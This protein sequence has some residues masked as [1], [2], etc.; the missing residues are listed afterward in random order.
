MKR[1]LLCTLLMTSLAHASDEDPECRGRC[2]ASY[3]T[4]TQSCKSPPGEPF[5][6]RKVTACSNRCLKEAGRCNRVCGSK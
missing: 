6:S 2:S 3:Q 4:C 5:D 1:W